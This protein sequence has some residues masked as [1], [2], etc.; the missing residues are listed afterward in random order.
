MLRR[1]NE[2]SST[3]QSENTIL[4]VYGENSVVVALSSFSLAGAFDI[5]P[6]AGSRFVQR[7]PAA[8]GAGGASGGGAGGNGGP[9]ACI[10]L[11]GTASVSGNPVY[12]TGIGG[13]FGTGGSGGAQ[14]SGG[15]CSGPK[16]DDGKT[17]SVGNTLQY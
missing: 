9:S 6:V 3:D 13:S 12:Y 1:R 15:I 8:G 4:S 14:V 11:V 5:R 2:P 17:G 7:L 16:G 10:A